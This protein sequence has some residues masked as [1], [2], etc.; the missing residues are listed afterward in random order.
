MSIA[1]LV[2]GIIAFIISFIPL[3]RIIAIFPA[4]TSIVLAIVDLVKNKN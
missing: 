1:S 3:I 2:L 4:I